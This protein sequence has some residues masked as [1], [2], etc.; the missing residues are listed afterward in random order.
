MDHAIT[1]ADLLAFGIGGFLCV[2][3]LVGVWF[4]GAVKGWWMP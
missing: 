2:L 4:T 3:F 1:V